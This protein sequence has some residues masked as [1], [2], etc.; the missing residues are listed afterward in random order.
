MLVDSHCHLDFEVLHIQLEDVLNRAHNNDVKII[1]TI[2][3]KI[4][5]FHNILSV[6]KS[7]ESIFCSV[8]IHPLNVSE[9]RF[10]T[11]EEIAKFVSEDK[12]IGIGETGLD[13]YHTQDNRIMQRKNFE[14]H[15]QAAQLSGVPLIIHTRDA[16]NDI[17]DMIKSVYKEKEFQAVMHCFTASKKLAYQC[18]DLGF[19]ISASGIITFK[20]AKDIR[21]LF[22]E[23]PIDRILIETDAPYL[24]PTPKRGQVNEPAFLS[25]TANFLANLRSITYDRLSE[26]T[27]DNFFQLFSKAKLK[28]EKV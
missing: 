11:P 16:D 15:I 23:L 13:Y 4:S 3:T 24:A 1:Q 10:Y 21:E 22:L 8:G 19:Y 6:A 9:E 28:N 26:I 25:Y 18:L 5:E 14:A 12:V 20:N 27:T 17:I 7:N 2:C